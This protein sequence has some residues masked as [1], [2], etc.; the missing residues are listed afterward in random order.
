MKQ[1]EE[2][3]G[4]VLNDEYREIISD[5]KSTYVV[6]ALG[7]RLVKIEAGYG[8]IDPYYEISNR[9]YNMRREL[10]KELS[11]RGFTLEDA[12][13]FLPYKTIAG[14]AGMGTPTK[15][16]LLANE[17]LGTLFALEIAA[18]KGV[19]TDKIVDLEGLEMPE[20]HPSCSGC[21][22]CEKAC[23]CSAIGSSLQADRCLRSQQ[24]REDFFSL[25]AARVSSYRLLG[26]D[27]CRRVC[28]INKAVPVREL[29][30]K[31]RELLD[32]DS[33][34]RAFTGGK[35]A[36]QPYTVFLGTNYLRPKKLLALTLNCMAN[37]HDPEKYFEYASAQL[38]N[39][40]ARVRCAAENLM[41]A[42]EEKKCIPTGAN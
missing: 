1:I 3:A 39:D 18:V 35:A 40:D 20:Y 13:T 26:C 2:I 33:L 7:Y 16:S 38:E 27:T 5:G 30:E 21:N 32:L 19:Y 23:P 11:D 28:P 31:E 29:T 6:F 9:A 4:Y 14:A 37:S 41:K 24:D 22:L 42:A 34:Y 36:R 12:H 17:K 25:P 8:Y 15:C 10:E